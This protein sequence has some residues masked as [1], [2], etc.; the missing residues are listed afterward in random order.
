MFYVFNMAR[1][2]KYTHVIQ[3]HIRKQDYHEQRMSQT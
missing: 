3:T 2:M 1:K